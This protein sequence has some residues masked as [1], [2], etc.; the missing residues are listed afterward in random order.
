VR[1]LFIIFLLC[2]LPLRVWAAQ[3]MG[4]AMGAPA[5]AGAGAAEV[6]MFMEDCPVAQGHSSS[7]DASDD[8]AAGQACQSCELC[9]SLGEGP[10]R[11]PVTSQLQRSPP[12]LAG[13]P[14]FCS[15]LPLPRL[16]PPIA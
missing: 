13:E 14:S 16:K 12:P 6:M 8:A 2:T 15:T 7:D 4:L 5:A 11:S 3:S 1:K 9:M 10:D